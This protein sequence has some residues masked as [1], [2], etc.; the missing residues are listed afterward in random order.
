MTRKEY[1]K[2]RA[3]EALCRRIKKRYDKNEKNWMKEV[4]EIN[5]FLLEHEPVD[6]DTIIWNKDLENATESYML[7]GAWILDRLSGKNGLHDRSSYSVKIKKMLG[8]NIKT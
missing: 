1:N 6:K 4:E 8:Y 2:K 7:R 5:N 3:F